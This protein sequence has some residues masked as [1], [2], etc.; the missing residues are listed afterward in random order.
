[1][2]E[3]GGSPKPPFS[4]QDV[5]QGSQPQLFAH[6]LERL[7]LVITART[8]SINITLIAMRGGQIVEISL[9]AC[10]V[11]PAMFCNDF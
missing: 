9:C 2:F 4:D 11:C 3:K 10:L 1:M 8:P 5:R 7:D 6:A